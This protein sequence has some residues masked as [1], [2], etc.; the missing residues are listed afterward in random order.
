MAAVF[1]EQT[2]EKEAL[3]KFLTNHNYNI[4]ICFI[5][6]ILHIKNKHTLQQIKLTNNNNN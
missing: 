5:T 2:T 1:I 6:D 4:H 3:A